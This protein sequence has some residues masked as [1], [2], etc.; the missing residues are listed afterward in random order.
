[1]QDRVKWIEISDAALASNIAALRKSLPQD[2]ILSAVVKANAYGH[3]LDVVA[4]V[5]E[6]LPGVDAFSIVSVDEARELRDLGIRKP[7]V[8]LGCF[9]FSDFDGIVETNT[10]PFVHSE[11]VAVSL[12]A[13]AEKARRT[14]RVILKIDTGM[15]RLGAHPEDAGK[16]IDTVE[17]A[18]H[19]ELAGFATHFAMSDIPGAKLTRTQ[20]ESFKTLIKRH[21][22]NIVPPDMT[23]T[24]NSGAIILESNPD[25]GMAR[26]GIAI[27]GLHPSKK[28]REARPDMLQPALE[29]KARIVDIKTLD[30]GGSV[31]YGAT[32]TAPKESRIAIL[33]VGYADGY[34][35][36]FSNRAVALVRGAPAPV[37]G[38]VCMDF[39]MLDISDIPGV[40]IGDT[41]TLISATPDSPCSADKLAEIAETINYEITTALPEALDRILV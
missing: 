33:P 16:L 8:L 15:G 36:A 1:M 20:I 39:T 35:R 34:R 11:P 19:L 14:V 24:D 21:R 31:S 12:E 13:A 5:L 25:G 28:S 26:P 27:Y 4:P 9:P 18:K 22:H 17:H 30:K 2:T 29:Y 32:W 41:A 6:R 10:I 37:R 40:K 38:T 23:T 7:I 3:G